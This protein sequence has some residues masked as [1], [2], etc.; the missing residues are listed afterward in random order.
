[1]SEQFDTPANAVPSAS[2]TNATQNDPG[3]KQNL[4]W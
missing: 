1:M 3:K 4:P 2:G